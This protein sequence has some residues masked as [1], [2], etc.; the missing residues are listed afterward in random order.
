MFLSII[1]STIAPVTLEALEVQGDLIFW[2]SAK[3]EKAVGH[4]HKSAFG[5]NI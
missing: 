3:N 4:E 1:R 2:C 5:R